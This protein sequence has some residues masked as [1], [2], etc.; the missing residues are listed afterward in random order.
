MHLSSP[1]DLRTAATLP[2]EWRATDLPDGSTLLRIAGVERRYPAWVFGTIA[3]VWTWLTL[4]HALGHRPMPL[5]ADPLIAGVLE[6]LLVA[7]TVWCAL[8]DQSWTLAPD[9][10]ESRVGIGRTAHVRQFQHAQ[11]RTVERTSRNWNVPYC[12]LYA[13]VDG[14]SHFLMDRRPD[15]L[16]SL[17]YFIAQRTGWSLSDVQAWPGAETFG[18][19]IT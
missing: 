1:T 4:S 11:L 3:A 5:D 19:R 17:A 10:L 8:A 16:R 14:R 2:P 13:V 15:E 7:L 9:L 12:R 18:Q 6:V